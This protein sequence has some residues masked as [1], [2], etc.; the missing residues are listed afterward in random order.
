M[1]APKKTKYHKA[2]K[3]RKR[4]TG[5]ASSRNYLAFG[6]FG[7]KTLETAWITDR[8]IEA[9]RRAISKFIKKGGKI[10]LRIFPDKPITKKPPEVPMGGGKGSV[11]H[12]VAPVKAGTIIFEMTGL[13]EELAREAFRYASHKLPVKT[14]FIKK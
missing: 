9:A 5:Q 6:D 10:W 12:W 13:K 4:K 14:K 7:L 1:L 11:D 3:G 2:Q 8:Q